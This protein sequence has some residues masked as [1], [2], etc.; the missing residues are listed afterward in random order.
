MAEAIVPEAIGATA[1]EP[2]TPRRRRA[3]P[4]ARKRK[5]A[6]TTPQVPDR[7]H[8]AMGGG[9]VPAADDEEPRGEPAAAREDYAQEA[10]DDDLTTTPAV[11]EDEAAAAESDDDSA[12]DVYDEWH[13]FSDLGRLN[14]HPG[15]VA[16]IFARQ[17][18]RER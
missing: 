16:Y 6:R 1:T 5:E 9:P 7:V 8:E 11:S 17:A 10:E 3:G 15:S 4:S 12:E 13:A 18:E 14:L 2:V